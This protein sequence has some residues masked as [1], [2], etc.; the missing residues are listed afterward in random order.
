MYQLWDIVERKSK[1]YFFK[2]PPKRLGTIEEILKIDIPENPDERHGPKLQIEQNGELVGTMIKSSVGLAQVIITL[3]ENYTCN[4]DNW[5][6]QDLYIV[7]SVQNASDHT[8]KMTLM[9]MKISSSGEI[10]PG[11]IETLLLQ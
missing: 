6:R 4:E 10:I 8:I 3:K 5:G 9:N 7:T 1:Y 11:K 2:H